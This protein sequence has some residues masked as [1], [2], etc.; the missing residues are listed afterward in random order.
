MNDTGH[1]FSG[2]P[3]S[4]AYALVER[5]LQALRDNVFVSTPDAV[6]REFTELRTQVDADILALKR[7]LLAPSLAST[8]DHKAAWQWIATQHRRLARVARRM[9]E[10]FNRLSGTADAA[11][12]LV[13]LALHYMG[14]SVKGHVKESHHPGGL[15][16]LM[17]I[18]LASRRHREEMQLD[19][20]GRLATCTLAALYFRAL[21]LAGLA[22]GG[23]TSAQAEI[24]DEWM[25]IW[26]P[27]LAGVDSPPEG[28]AWRADLDSNQGLR[29][30]GRADAGPS[31]YLPRARLEAARL[32]IVREF[33]CG[34]TVPASGDVSKLAIADHIVVLDAVRRSLRRVR[35]EPVARAERFAYAASVEVQ[36]GLGEV[37]AKGFAAKVES[38]SPLGLV[39]T[40]AIGAGASRGDR[41]HDNAIGAIGAIYD[42]PRR[43]VQMINMSDTGIGFE[44]GERDCAE[45]MVGDLV[46]L[47]VIPGETPAL[48]KVVSRIAGAAEGRSVVTVPCLPTH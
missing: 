32:A 16:A 48:G 20:G 4:H 42:A 29:I 12:G 39:D 37:M 30:G 15:H 7:R 47:C 14:E 36:V 41:E 6:L 25:W 44:G 43:V 45:I 46:G 8:D 31:L 5:R 3:D 21:L 17:R 22:G 2:A 38:A 27:A 40:E 33:H 19:V 18:A 11:W 1:Y 23:L 24:L 28:I 9:A 34:R 26:M 35:G 13:A 10:G